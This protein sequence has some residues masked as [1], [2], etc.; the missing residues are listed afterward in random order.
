MAI[1][2]SEGDVQFLHIPR[3]SK[4]RSA[5]SAR[6]GAQL[7]SS[8]IAELSKRWKDGLCEA[9]KGRP[10]E[11]GRLNETRAFYAALLAF[12]ML[13]VMVFF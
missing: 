1:A 7:R 10:A 5:S 3:I 2:E 6:R 8:A 12:V 4:E 11:A 13:F 9:R